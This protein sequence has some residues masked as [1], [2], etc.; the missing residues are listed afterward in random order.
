MLT[1]P[2]WSSAAPFTI[3]IGHEPSSRC[4]VGTHA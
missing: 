3:F 4:I 2:R 1:S